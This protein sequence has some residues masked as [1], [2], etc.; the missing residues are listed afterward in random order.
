MEKLDRLGWAAGISF[1][2]FGV[3]IGIRMNQ[4]SFMDRILLHLPPGWT[5]G[6]SRIVERLYSLVI[7]QGGTSAMVRRLHLLYGNSELLARSADLESVLQSFESS[8][9]LHVAE[10]APHKVFVHAGVVGWK[11]KAIVIPGRSFSGKST[12]VAEFVRAGA[13]YYSD[14]YAVLDV[15]GNVHPYS[16]PVVMRENGARKKYTAEELGGIGGI[17]PLPVGVLL[18][19]RYDSGAQWRPRE[20]SPG[21]GALALFENAVSARRHPK[22]A[23]LSIQ[24][25]M[26][27]AKGLKGGRGEAKHLVDEICNAA[28]Q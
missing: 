6:G 15:Q 25:A 23:L 18:V 24:K 5:P 2:S 16:R 8:V 1:K 27:Q 14:E 28:N 10:M 17:T 19:T 11:E 4:A 9:H 7:G 12:L 26:S 21:A 20:L 3:A 13:K 22:R